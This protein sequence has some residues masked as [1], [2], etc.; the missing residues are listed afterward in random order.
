MEPD[1]WNEY[2]IQAARVME[3]GWHML[4]WYDARDEEHVALSFLRHCAKGS[5][6]QGM[7][8]VALSDFLGRATRHGRAVAYV[9]LWAGSR[10]QDSTLDCGEGAAP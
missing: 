10:R 1:T 2:V 4:T 3:Q 6:T 9:L 5:T 8:H 7:K